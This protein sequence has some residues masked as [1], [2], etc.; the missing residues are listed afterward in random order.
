MGK[1]QCHGDVMTDGIKYDITQ[2]SMSGLTWLQGE[3]S[4]NHCLTQRYT[5]VF[6]QHREV[7][8]ADGGFIP[9]IAIWK[10]TSS[11]LLIKRGKKIPP[12]IDNH[13][14]IYNNV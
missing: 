10:T 11:R 3:L 2:P 4:G 8:M 12:F 1:P 6:I 14:M 7:R 13:P 9:K 5:D